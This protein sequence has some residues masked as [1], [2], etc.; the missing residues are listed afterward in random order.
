VSLADMVSA[1]HERFGVAT[2]DRSEPSLRMGLRLVCE[3]AFEVLA[4]AMP[5]RKTS[6]RAFEAEIQRWIAEE[7]LVPDWPAMVDGIA[8]ASWVLEGL[9]QRLGIDMAPVYELVSAANMAKI[10]PLEPG[11]KIAKPP[12]WE[13]PDIAGE[14]GRQWADV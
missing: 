7:T 10:P 11:G 13:P 3:E 1:F 5:H 8:D 2:P 6:L 4:A 14:V 12:G 9:A